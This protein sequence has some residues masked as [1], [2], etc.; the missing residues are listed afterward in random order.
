MA[1]EK[2][3]SY[4]SLKRLYHTRKW[5]R[6][7]A[8]VINQSGGRCALCGKLITGHFVIN[9]KKLATR[10]N[11]FDLDNLELLCLSCHNSITIKDGGL[12]RSLNDIYEISEDTVSDLIEY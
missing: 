1:L 2:K 7:Q 4:L 3:A 11:F 6:T 5:K 9:H 10:E 12:K 8:I